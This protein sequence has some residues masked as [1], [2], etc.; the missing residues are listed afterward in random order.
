MENTEKYINW[1]QAF[2][3]LV[4]GIFALFKNEMFIDIFYEYKNYFIAVTILFLLINIYFLYRS[5]K[6]RKL[7]KIIVTCVL[8]LFISLLTILMLF[9]PFNEKAV[10][11]IYGFYNISDDGYT[12]TYYGQQIAKQIKDKID[13]SYKQH[14]LTKADIFKE[15]KKIVLSGWNSSV[16]QNM[17]L[18]LIDKLASRDEKTPFVLTG[19]VKDKKLVGISFALNK[20]ILNGN[21]QTIETEKRLIHNVLN[22]IIKSSLN[23][24]EK[25][26]L[27][28]NIIFIRLNAAF[29]DFI[30]VDMKEHETDY[31]VATLI[32]LLDEQI[33]KYSFIRE[34]LNAVAALIVAAKNNHY[35][36]SQQYEKLA[37]NIL[38]II[39][40]NKYYPY[41]TREEFYKAYVQN[42][43]YE[44]NRVRQNVHDKK[45]S[46]QN[47]EG[48]NSLP[49]LENAFDDLGHTLYTMPYNEIITFLDKNF[50][51]EVRFHMDEPIFLIYWGDY[52]K[53]HHDLML[54]PS[55]KLSII[56]KI[57]EKYQK[58]A[59]HNYAKR[60]ELLTAVINMKISMSYLIKSSITK[61]AKEQEF[62]VGKFTEYLQKASKVIKQQFGSA[63]DWPTTTVED[64]SSRIEI[65]LNEHALLLSEDKF[66][67]H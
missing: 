17:N 25:Y 53:I 36:R 3:V 67:E 6:D 20:N 62:C 4:S 34:D 13:D 58:A 40:R 42:Y 35:F 11:K 65:M 60:N 63:E 15:H 31:F 2:Y 56:D 54:L 50:S 39:K 51:E 44:V 12:T 37:T 24:N 28:A 49:N 48:A 33:E 23:D 18:E 1:M 66:R 10:L 45:R 26:D 52:L 16:L 64:L 46:I 29:I 21:E 32:R 5:I 47:V 57:E 55:E 22:K 8:T 19:V 7:K 38:E 27:I 9:D 14:M 43:L 61:N 30:A 59:K 41:T